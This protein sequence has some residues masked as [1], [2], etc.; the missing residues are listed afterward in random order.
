MALA[1]RAGRCSIASGKKS[2]RWQASMTWLR[3]SGRS[4]E[5]AADHCPFHARASASIVG[6]RTPCFPAPRETV[7]LACLVIG[8][9]I[10]EYNPGIGAVGYMSNRPKRDLV[11]L[12]TEKDRECGS[13]TSERVEDNIGILVTKLT[14]TGR[15]LSHTCASLRLKL[16]PRL[17]QPIS[18][19][20][21]DWLW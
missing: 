2:M 18:C 19:Q 20:S 1:S 7:T 16:I 8:F 14:T 10:A 11:A 5:G 3:C 9:C 12:V 15:F 17:R 6:L 4:C 21:G 13:R